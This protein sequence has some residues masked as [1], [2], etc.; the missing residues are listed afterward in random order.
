MSWYVAPSLQQ[1]RDEV[2]AVWPGRDKTSDGS[3]GD[4]SHLARKSAHNPAPATD[5]SPGVVRA[6]DFDKDGMDSWRLV[7]VAINDPRTEVVIYSGSHWS[8]KY[9]FERRAYYGANSHHGHV[10]VEIRP[11]KKYENDTRAWGVA[12]SST[13]TAAAPTPAPEAHTMA[14]ILVRT[15]SANPVVWFVDGNTKR[16]LSSGEDQLLFDSGLVPSVTPK[17]WPVARVEAMANWAPPATADALATLKAVTD[18]Q[19]RQIT[20]IAVKVGA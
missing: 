5:P 9:G 20:A 6:R 14:G 4:L 16:I 11:G 13:P 2:N 19:G 15:D 1:L 18:G 17:W 3:V 10:H 12:P 8:R 7:T